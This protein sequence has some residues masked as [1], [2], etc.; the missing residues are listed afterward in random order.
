MIVLS[1]Q[2]TKK[3]QLRPW[4]GL[5]YGQA[6]L[7]RVWRD[8]LRSFDRLCRELTPYQSCSS[9]IQKWHWSRRGLRQSHQASSRLNL[10][11]WFS[12]CRLD[13]LRRY[14]YLPTELKKKITGRDSAGVGH[15]MV[16]GRSMY[17]STTL[18]FP[19]NIEIF[20]RGL[21]HEII[22]SD[23]FFARSF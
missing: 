20:F 8:W 4:T 19:L 9:Q 1:R 18:R 10:E 13:K 23:Q 15:I 5:A 6:I 14:V 7:T 3:K 12:T 21:W 22:K 11:G 2:E 16:V 17:V